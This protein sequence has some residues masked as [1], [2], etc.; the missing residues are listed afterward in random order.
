L[1]WARDEA[2]ARRTAREW[3][4]TAGLRGSLTQ[5]LPLP[6]HLEQAARTVR[7]EDV[8]ERV[9]CGPDPA[10]HIE[11]ILAFAR[12]GFGH[13][14]V[15][16]VGPD[17]GGF[18]GPSPAR[19]R[20]RERPRRLSFLG[21]GLRPPSEP[22]PGIAPAKPALEQSV[23]SSQKERVKCPERRWTHDPGAC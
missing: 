3:W 19:R 23:H 4:P 7:E 20:S 15:H 8:A 5:E 18:F 21:G 12:A 9:V 14:Y 22:P 16:Q 11:K 13:V 6:M 1:S 10:R 2:A 17:Q